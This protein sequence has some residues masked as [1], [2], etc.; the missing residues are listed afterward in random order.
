[1]VKIRKNIYDI[2]KI[3]NFF[4]KNY[5]NKISLSIVLGHKKN[6]VIMKLIKSILKGIR[7]EDYPIS[8]P[9]NYG[10]SIKLLNTLKRQ[11]YTNYEAICDILDNSVDSLKKKEDISTNTINGNIY[12]DINFSKTANLL[13]EDAN[14]VICDNGIGFKNSDTLKEALKL[15]TELEKGIDL[16]EYLG[17]YGVGLKLSAISIGKLLVVITYN[18]SEY[19][20]GI[21]DTDK[22]FKSK[23][24]D[25]H[26]VRKS[27]DDEIN[28][29][30][31]YIKED[32]GTMIIINKI[33]EREISTS[34][35][36]QFTNIIK[37]NIGEI[38]RYF[39]SDQQNDGKINFF[40][41]DE[42]I[43]KIDPMCLDLP[44]TETLNKDDENIN[45]EYDINDAIIKIKYYFI[46]PDASSDDNRIPSIRNQGI[47]VLRNNRQ[48]LRATLFDVKSKHPEYNNFRCELFYDGKY[49]NIFKTNSKKTGVV[50]PDALISKLN[51]GLTIFLG[52]IRRRTQN[53]K[54]ISVDNDEFDKKIEDS[55]NKNP[56]TPN[57][58]FPDR[59][60]N[61]VE[62]TNSGIKRVD[63]NRTIKKVE[64]IKTQIGVRGVFFYP[65]PTGLKKWV[66]EINTDHPFYNKFKSL[67]FDSQRMIYNILYGVSLAS[68][69]E[70]YQ[71]DGF[72]ADSKE[73]DELIQR[74]FE[75][76][77]DKIKDI[78]KSQEK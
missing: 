49:D 37:K 72:N 41:K 9:L 31:S 40:V 7:E 34:N 67:N 5:N 69:E 77:S 18:G 38:F 47:Y 53:D 46:D 54:K 28:S 12:I 32:T 10:P 59:K 4:K 36:T 17:C 26:Y 66:L 64:F 78:I 62:T 39:I 74:F 45:F 50:L 13:N 43:N 60:P 75:S 2:I 25:F 27:T 15:G 55:L 22:A 19:L 42:L 48:I 58:T 20:T 8:A 76:W 21:F 3:I 1:M 56:L 30:K 61:T 68:Y 70:L 33:D 16:N 73:K 24:W 14:I 65:R 44:N 71:K 63:T 35:I 52:E 57:I 29:L 11:G 23:S 51:E 6:K